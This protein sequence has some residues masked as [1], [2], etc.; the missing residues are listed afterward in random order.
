LVRTGPPLVEV[1]EGLGLRLLAR[2]DL[3]VALGVEGVLHDLAERLVADRENVTG[4]RG[5]VDSERLVEGLAEGVVRGTQQS[6][7]GLSLGFDDLDSPV[8]ANEVCCGEELVL[9]V[10]LGLGFHIIL[11]TPER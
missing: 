1:H 3:V 4:S 2:R 6:Q 7:D 8:E 10:D 9:D 5:L 11:S